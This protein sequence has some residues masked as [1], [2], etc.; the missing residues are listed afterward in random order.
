MAYNAREMAAARQHA[1]RALELHRRSSGGHGPARLGALRLKASVLDAT[2][3]HEGARA[4]YSEALALAE[5]AYGPDHPHVASALT[6]LAR[7][8]TD[9]GDFAAAR[10]GFERALCATICRHVR[11]ARARV[12]RGGTRRR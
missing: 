1:D 8:N 9:S 10:T 6:L 3:D 4:L 2:G 12:G 11:C 5:T 7:W